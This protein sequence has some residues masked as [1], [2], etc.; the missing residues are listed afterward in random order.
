MRRGPGAWALLLI[1]VVGG[2]LPSSQRRNDRSVSPADSASAA[3]AATVPVDTLA[4]VWRARAPEADPMPLPTS[5][6]WVSGRVVVAEAREGRL[7]RFSAAGEHGGHVD[8]GAQAYPY[9][10]GARG[11]TAVV[12]ARGAGELLWV[13]GR[14]VVRRVPAPGARNAVAAPGLLAVRRGGGP[15]STATLVRLDET[16]AEVARAEVAPAWRALGF[17]RARGDTIVALSGYRPVVDVWAPGA[18]PDTLA[19]AGFASPQLI[20]SA[21]FMRGEADEPPLLTS[22]AAVLGDRLLVLNLRADHTRIDVYDAGGTIERVLVSPR[23]WAPDEAVPL[24]LAVRERD[25]AVEIGV[26]QARPPGVLRAPD[27]DVV[28]YRWAVPRPSGR[29]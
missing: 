9:L 8:L 19:L 16:G 15:D 27:A 28:L 24:D 5:L 10:A 11:D 12:L 25:G 2:C 3:L 6:A 18:A 26:L 23:P 1:A 20:R 13:R 21:Q 29:R 4:L 14:E 7:H 22:S 17:V